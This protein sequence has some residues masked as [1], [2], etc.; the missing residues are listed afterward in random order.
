MALHTPYDDHRTQVPPR[1][2]PVQPGPQPKS[3]GHDY[4]PTHAV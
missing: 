2:N 4:S 3:I 1:R